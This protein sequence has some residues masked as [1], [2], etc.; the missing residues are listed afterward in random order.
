MCE[1]KDPGFKYYPAWFEDAKKI[2][3]QPER[4][5]AVEAARYW[6]THQKP[7]SSKPKL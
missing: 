7:I 6:L 2:I 4:K 5:A 1:C 3:E